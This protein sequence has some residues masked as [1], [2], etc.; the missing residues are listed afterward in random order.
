MKCAD[1]TDEQIYEAIWSCRAD[2]DYAG[3][4]W[5]SRWDIQDRFLNVPHKVIDA[6]LYLMVRKHRLNG[7]GANHNCRGDFY[8]PGEE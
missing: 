8:L 7:C 6:K 2:P 1:I 4:L 3:R 5:V